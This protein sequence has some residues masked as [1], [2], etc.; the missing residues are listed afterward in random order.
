MGYFFHKKKRVFIA[1]NLSSRFSVADVCEK[2]GT[3]N[4]ID[5]GAGKGYLSTFLAFEYGLNVI[6]IDCVKTNLDGVNDRGRKNS[7]L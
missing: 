1:R 5:V 4:V 3:K 7:R 6:A 2:A